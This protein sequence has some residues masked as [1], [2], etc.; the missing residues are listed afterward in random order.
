MD[1]S[2]AHERS[3]LEARIEIAAKQLKCLN[4]EIEAKSAEIEDL[5]STGHRYQLLDDICEALDKLENL[6]GSALF[7]GE[8]RSLEDR[9]RHLERVRSVIAGF[10]Q[11]RERIE[12]EKSALEQRAQAQI[13]EISDL[14]DELDTVLEEEEARKNEYILE[15][16]HRDSQFR[17]MLMPWITHRSDRIRF[18]KS[19]GGVF[20]CLLLFNLL[21]VLWELPDISQE[22]FEIPEYLVEMVKK[23]KPKPQPP[24]EQPKVKEERKPEEQEVAKAEEKPE[25][26]PELRQA[27]RKTAET[28]GVLAFKESFQD[29]LADDVDQKLGAAAN[30]SN[31]ASSARGDASRNL[32]MSQAQQS[33]GGINNSA[34]SRSVGGTAVGQIGQGVAFARV[35]SAIG[36]DMIADDRPLSDGVGPT[37]TDEE[38]Q[39]VFD[40]YKAALYRI[41]NRELRVNPLLKG[42][43]V[44][45]ITIESDGSVSL[46]KVDSTNMDSP[47]LV[48]EVLS[49]VER[50]NFGPKEGVPAITILYPIDFLPAG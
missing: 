42:K 27:A 50:F 9:D 35:E 33:S 30:L 13:G 1:F 45:R 6:G 36:T 41:Y 23:E 25:P 8:Q 38:I 5:L 48:A 7:W 15:R 32:V 10:S 39:I 14:Q 11:E 18:Y 4:D 28:A 47:A 12:A 49:R 31:T 3:A 37:R 34:V 19:L 2:L 16:E 29:L 46:A 26:S 17:P 21:I 44:L 22:P 24:I 43:M 20:A 40:R